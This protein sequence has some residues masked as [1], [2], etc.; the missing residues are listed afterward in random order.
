MLPIAKRGALLFLSENCLCAL[1]QK[2]FDMGTGNFKQTLSLAQR[3]A[4]HGSKIKVTSKLCLKTI[5]CS[6][7]KAI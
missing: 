5:M 6:F 7:S 2:S 4:K 3:S 1:I